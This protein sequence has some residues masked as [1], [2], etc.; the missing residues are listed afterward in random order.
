MW[1]GGGGGGWRVVK[2]GHF[3]IAVGAA[4][5]RLTF[6]VFDVMNYVGMCSNSVCECVSFQP[7]FCSSLV[8]SKP[9][10]PCPEV[11]RYEAKP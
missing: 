8:K 4:I 1:G 7:F 11:P 5:L 10:W 3:N 6:C 9:Q 2:Y